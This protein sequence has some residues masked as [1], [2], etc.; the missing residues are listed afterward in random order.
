MRY[1]QGDGVYTPLDWL[2]LYP[3]SVLVIGVSTFVF[4]WITLGTAM[5]C[6]G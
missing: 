5:C 3:R 1:S 2:V 4:S 6:K